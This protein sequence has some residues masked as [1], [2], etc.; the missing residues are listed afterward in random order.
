MNEFPIRIGLT[1]DFYNQFWP[2]IR[3]SWDILDFAERQ[4]TVDDFSEYNVLPI[5]EIACSCGDEELLQVLEKAR[6]R[7]QFAGAYLASIRI[8]AR[9]RLVCI[10]AKVT[11]V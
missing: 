2:I 8:G 4:Q 10:L 6:V 3:P 5:E 1:C 9:I 11:W 7:R